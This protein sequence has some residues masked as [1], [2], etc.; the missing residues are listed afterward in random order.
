MVCTD[1]LYPSPSRRKAQVWSNLTL[2]T[3]WLMPRSHQNFRPL[4]AVKFM[5]VGPPLFHTVTAE[6]PTDG[7]CSETSVKFM[8][9]GPPLFTL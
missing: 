9:V 5:G 8:G 2:I 6:M 4:P 3:I 7:A 1:S